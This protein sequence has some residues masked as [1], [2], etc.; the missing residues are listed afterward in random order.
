MLALYTE[1]LVAL[2][3]PSPKQDISVVI[4]SESVFK[5]SIGVSYE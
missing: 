3:Y 5:T 1:L 2:I 4:A